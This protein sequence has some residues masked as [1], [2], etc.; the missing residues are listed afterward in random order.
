[1]FFPREA[2]TIQL[3]TQNAGRNVSAVLPELLILKKKKAKNPDFV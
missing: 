3:Y 2:A 1:M